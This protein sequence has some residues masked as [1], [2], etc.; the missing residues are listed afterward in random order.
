MHYFEHVPDLTE[1]LGLLPHAKACLFDM[2]GTLIDT[3]I[4]HAK[5]FHKL[6]ELDH[7]GV[8]TDQQL[9]DLCLGATDEG[10]FRKLQE[11]DYLSKYQIEELKNKKNDFY[12]EYLETSLS[13]DICHP[14]ITQLL[15]KIKH[16]GKKIGLVTSSDELCA[17]ASMKRLGLFAHFDVFVT[18]ESTE[19]N[20]PDPAPYVK[21]CADL[22]LAPQECIVFEDSPTGLQAAKAFGPGAIIHARWY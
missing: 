6:L 8:F 18:Q 1:I 4:L 17:T 9:H 15:E 3:E 11:Q 22:G 20:K 14:Q 2:D 5:A 7:P 16:S 21:A 13:A 10:V 12:L 19:L